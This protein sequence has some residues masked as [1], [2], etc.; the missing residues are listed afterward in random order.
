MALKTKSEHRQS[1]VKEFTYVTAPSSYDIFCFGG[2]YLSFYFPCYEKTED[3]QMAVVDALI[4]TLAKFYPPP[5]NQ[6]LLMDALG[7]GDE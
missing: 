1:K 6:E 2:K 4:E 7:L 3:G 5:N